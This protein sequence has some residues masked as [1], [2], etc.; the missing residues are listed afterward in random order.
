MENK[1]LAKTKDE[2]T[3]IG[4]TESLIKNYALLKEYYPSIKNLDW[5]L[6]KLACLYHD[7]GKLNTKFQNK[8]M[9]KLNYPLLKD[10]LEDIN[11]IPHG[12]L[13]PAF[14]DLEDIQEKYELDG[15]KILCQSI[16][17]HH[18][19]EKPDNPDNIKK[20][21]K[22]D[23]SKYI[24]EFSYERIGKVSE[25]NTK[26]WKYVK[27]RLPNQEIEDD[28]E[29]EEKRNII[30]KKFIMTKGLLN[31]IDYAASSGVPIEYKNDELE[32]RTNDFFHSMKSE[33][34]KL[35]KFMKE[36]RDNNII[37][38]ASTGIGKT[39]GALLWIGD[40]KGF[41]TLPLRVSLNAIYD[42]LKDKIKFD[43]DKLGLLHSESATEYMKRSEGHIDKDHLDETKQLSK[44]LTVC[45]L[46]QLLDFVFKCEGFELKLATLS[47]SKIVIDE[48]QMYSSDM[49][50]YLLTAL[51]EITDMGGKFAIVTATFPPV[52]KS[53]MEYL[54]IDYKEAEQPF[55]KENKN[56]KTFERHRMK[57]LN[58]KININHIKNNYENKRILVIVNTVKEAQRLYDELL[59]EN[60][61]NINIFHSKYIKKDRSE[62]EKKILEAGEV[63]NGIL[64]N[65]S[66]TIWITTQIVEASL[67]IDFDVLYT[68]LS[69]LS[70]LFQRMG[71]V[72]R[73]RGLDENTNVYVYT[74]GNGA[75]SGIRKSKKSIID[76]DIY[77]ASRQAI[78]EFG[79]GEIRETDK[80]NLINKYFT[81]ER[82][83][84]SN[85]YM[86]V[87]QK[88]NYINNLKCFELQKSEVRLRDILTT[89][90]IPKVVYEDNYESINENI[91]IY[92]SDDSSYSDRIKSRD[93][94]LG[95]TVAIPQYEYEFACNKGL[96]FDTLNIGKY[97]EIKVVSFPYNEK[98]LQKP[99]NKD[100]SDVEC[101]FI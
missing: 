12:Y 87:K 71:R 25:L 72:Y 70:G 58:E 49:L 14:L 81:Y 66:Q 74:G 83:G 88:I 60:I 89:T 100:E 19:R 82:L 101:L 91:R 56:G 97:E 78:E 35:Q 3:I 65:P 43:N 6:L 17:Y 1:A 9:S 73:N 95:Y 63:I 23:L 30:N 69:D 44:A 47:Y 32:K 45:T 22:E 40:N 37:A 75:P 85:F 21:I 77:C 39:E 15:L 29:E 61:P 51:K 68:E 79:D 33:P 41:F 13:S 36:N 28:K 10:E 67:D 59:E 64:K 7:M 54:K 8:L 96:I 52:L 4:H 92:S 5:D 94:I 18:N 24:N 31:K 34:N 46:D 99:K 90:I 48:I 20:T 84:K 76:H 11:E 42:R 2:E 16:F 86:D 38:I 55:L 50:A 93:Y 26:Y 80:M 98:G 62:I 27:R 53:F 57:V